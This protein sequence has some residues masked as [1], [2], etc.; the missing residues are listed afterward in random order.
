[1]KSSYWFRL[2]LFPALL[3]AMF[4]PSNLLAVGDASTHFQ[5]FVPPNNDNVGR[6][7]ALIITNVSPF[8]T[9]VDL[10]DVG[11]DGDTDD[12]VLGIEL[13]RGQSY[14]R[15]I[16]DGAVND[17]AGG[18]WDGDYFIVRSQDPVVVQMSTDSDW[19]WDFVPAD[20]KTMRGQ[21]FF[22]YSPPTS[23]SDRDINLVA[24]EDDTE[25]YILDI[26]VEAMTQT[27]LTSVDLEN[28]R[29]ILKAV[30]NRGEDLIGRNN[31]GIDIL[32]PGRTYWVRA[33][34][35]V[36]CQYGSLVGNGRD[37]AG[38]VPSENGFSS[39]ENFYFFIPADHPNEREVRIVSFDDDNLVE[40]MGWDRELRDWVTIRTFELDR[41]GHGDW[42]ESGTDYPL[43]HLRCSPGKKVSVFAASW[44]EAKGLNATKDIAS[45]ASSESG[46]GAGREFLVY[47]PQPGRQD[48]V[49][50]SG[51]PIGNNSHLFL[52]GYL[53]GTE[54]EVV[55]AA[56]QGAL[57]RRTGTIAR[58][59]YANVRMSPAEFNLLNRPAEGIR[60]YLHIKSNKLITVLVT[61]FNDNWMTFVPS[62]VLPNPILGVGSDVEVARVG[63]QVC[64]NFTAD[65][66]GV[67][68]LQAAMLEVVLDHAV[69]YVS[70]VLSIP[71]LGEP[72]IETTEDGRSLLTWQDFVIPADGSLSGTICFEIR[73]RRPDNS[74]V[75]NKDFIDIPVLVRGAGFGTPAE[76]GGV[77]EIFTAQSSLVMTID[78]LDQTSVTALAATVIDPNIRVTWRTTREPDLSGFHVYRSTTGDGAFTRITQSSIG[79][80]GD[81]L[82]GANYAFLDTS[83]QLGRI[84]YY[85]LEVI[86]IDGDSTFLGPVA[87]FAEDRTPPP[88]PLISVISTGDNMIGLQVTGGN[89][90]GDLDG[91]AI[92]RSTSPAGPFS[93]LN[94]IL[95]SENG[96][97]LDRAAGNGTTYY[98]R[99]RA[100]DTARNQS[101]FSS[102]V[103]AILPSALDAVYTLAY[104][105]Q[106]G[107]T[108]NDW[109]YNDWVVLV[110]STEQF[111]DGGVSSVDV[112][113]EA[114]ARGARWRN[115]FRFHYRAAGEWAAK[116]SI[117]ENRDAELPES[118][119]EFNGSG[120]I[121]LQIF[122]DTYD[123][124]PPVWG[125]PD[126]EEDFTNTLNRQDIA[127]LGKVALV[128]IT[129]SSP[130][131]NPSLERHRP[132]F[133]PYLKSQVGEVHLARE[134]Y[135]NSTE[136][137]RLW[138]DSPLLGYN[139]DYVLMVPG[140]QWRWPLENQKIWDAYPGKF[141][142]FILSGGQSDIDWHL[143]G[144]RNTARTYNWFP[145]PEPSKN[146]EQAA[147]PESLLKV[148][149]EPLVAFPTTFVASIQGV[150]KDPRLPFASNI[151]VAGSDGLI[152]LIDRE[153]VVQEG[154]PLEANSYRS[155]PAWGRLSQS[156]S[157]PVLLTAEERYDGNARLIAWDIQDDIVMR[158]QYD[159]GGAVKSPPVIVDLENNGEAEVL[160]ISTD[161]NLHVVR[162]DGSPA[163]ATPL[164]LGP[165]IWNDKN[166]LVGGAP[167]VADIDGDGRAAIFA[168]TP[169][170][171]RVNGYTSTLQGLPGWPVEASAPLVGGIA[172]A[173]S[174]EDERFLLV[175]TDVNGTLHGWDALGRVAPGFP[176][177][178]SG[179]VIAPTV[180]FQD[181]LSGSH[182]LVVATTRGIVYLLDNAGNVLPNWPRQIEGEI[183]ASPVV[184]DLD[185]DG[186]LAILCASQSG[187]V[188]AWKLD[189]TPLAHFTFRVNGAVQSTPLL[190]DLNLDARL[191]VYVATAL[192]NVYRVESGNQSALSVTEAL[193]WPAV[194]GPSSM[195]TGNLE[196]VPNPTSTVASRIDVVRFLLGFLVDIPFPLDTN[197][198]GVIDAADVER[199]IP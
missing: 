109:D 166:I 191:E 145:Y 22:V 84:Y 127:T 51:Q 54:Y 93:R 152:R 2:F 171:T 136:V 125:D 34:K 29:E 33:S 173:H 10:V 188:A 193:P 141:A 114:L 5:V 111:A 53:D 43:Y 189:G 107:P 69:D 99:A 47:V 31:L 20:N 45:F 63:E 168:A 103:S 61:N 44:L 163:M 18:K 174:F 66:A 98:Y 39:G 56:T 77:F 144:N 150:N 128:E 87:V 101:E 32:D 177:T 182:Y 75:K 25:V 1:M 133:G 179:Q 23:F 160:V 21:N 104:E 162:S 184:G 36:T 58:E 148:E 135:P 172:A 178:L 139:L 176:V 42:V 167:V 65:N 71:E 79:G 159:V 15:Y 3:F 19:Q 187:A 185:G 30:L 137:V 129:L 175:A 52:F 64:L 11:E 153:G 138:P 16:R 70:S 198:D 117:F 161:G 180:A 76:D 14:V 50:F 92:F 149:H 7:V 96:V 164:D 91:Y 83:A 8:S 120:A 190:A 74:P 26:T 165:R 186:S 154:W 90:D 95:V 68:S 27:G 123:A 131:L 140:N 118:V 126:R 124:L 17:D 155:T 49:R 158:W 113:I 121:D 183:I 59:G 35:P 86:D 46:Y 88:A 4:L 181:P 62:V 116:V 122:A 80:T 78:D 37:G 48:R 169:T 194:S 156:E 89:E 102:T 197:E 72:M 157:F 85:R 105:D 147:P 100:I 9:M 38:F 108:R 55:D 60:P 110:S 130:S 199:A 142:S 57:F 143:P 73:A 196:S 151:L 106:I 132:P 192:G 12:T 82:T 195:N 24:Y 41:F 112:R 67:G 13:G 6:H 115:S 146:P 28:P 40:F 94:E 81:A 97:Y 170:G 119:D 134:G